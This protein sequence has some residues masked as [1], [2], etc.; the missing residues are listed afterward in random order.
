MIE[1]AS[2]ERWKLLF[3]VEEGVDDLDDDPDAHGQDR[4][5]LVNRHSDIFCG[6]KEY[7]HVL[8]D[9]EVRLFLFEKEVASNADDIISQ[10]LREDEVDDVRYD[11]AKGDFII[12]LE[13]GFLQRLPPFSNWLG[14]YCLGYVFN[15]L[16]QVLPSRFL[17][18]LVE[19]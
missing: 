4:Y 12:V 16:V 18:Q 8:V 9:D 1:E 11:G 5:L 15:N 7:G 3:L 6:I 10:S 2:D 13:V 17:A 14:R 19:Y